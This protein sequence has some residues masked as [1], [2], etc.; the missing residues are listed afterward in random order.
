M[1]LTFW[2]ATGPA[3]AG[4]SF[5]MCH[6]YHEHHSDAPPEMRQLFEQYPNIPV[7]A[8]AP[9]GDWANATYRLILPPFRGDLGV[10]QYVTS[11]VFRENGAW[12]HSPPSPRFER[13]RDTV[14]MM[15]SEERCPSYDDRRYVITN[16]ITEGAF[17]AAIHLWER[18]SSGDPV[19]TSIASSA[20]QATPEFKR[21]MA[22]LEI[23]RQRQTSWKP[24]SVSRSAPDP[25]RK[26]IHYSIQVNVSK[27]G[28][29]LI[30]DFIDG[31]LRLM[32][33]HKIIY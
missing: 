31:D 19:D 11:P 14:Y 7:E 2:L 28:W 25:I 8:C 27:Q 26:P 20:V 22:A 21:L 33:V 23:D 16:D 3:Q 13:Q 6:V 15:A 10:C 5:D 24:D 12:T 30:V 18:L 4:V 32:D 1:A 9:P 29:L 17:I